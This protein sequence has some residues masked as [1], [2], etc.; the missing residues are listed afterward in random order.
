[1]AVYSLRSSNIKG[2]TEQAHGSQATGCAFGW[3]GV[4]EGVLSSP[5]LFLAGHPIGRGIASTSCCVARLFRM[6]FSSRRPG[7]ARL[8]RAPGIPN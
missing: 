3:P 8:P 2:D 6:G 5:W 4:E 7:V 1:M